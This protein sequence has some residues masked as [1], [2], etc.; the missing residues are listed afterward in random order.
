M[1]NVTTMQLATAVRVPKWKM[2]S[3]IPATLNA[4]ENTPHTNKLRGVSPAA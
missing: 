2:P 1:V 3:K 4:D